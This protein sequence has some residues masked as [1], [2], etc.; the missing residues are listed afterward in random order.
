M[1]RKMYLT[2]SLLSVKIYH[3]IHI[4]LSCTHLCELTDQCIMQVTPLFVTLCT[5]PSSGC[6]IITMLLTPRT[7]NIH[8]GFSPTASL[9]LYPCSSW[10]HFFLCQLIPWLSLWP[11]DPL[12]IFGNKPIYYL[13]LW[14]EMRTDDTLCVQDYCGAKCE[15]LPLQIGCGY[16]TCPKESKNS[17]FFFFNL[18]KQRAIWYIS[19]LPPKGL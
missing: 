14:G 4:L 11:Q 6:A 13:D 17:F 15:K 10:T 9:P 1:F 19:E 16:N 2:G 7:T 3:N 5:T 18:G 8:T 12:C